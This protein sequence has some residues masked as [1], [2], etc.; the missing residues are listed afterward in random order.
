MLAQVSSLGLSRGPTPHLGSEL[1]RQSRAAAASAC[2]SKSRE[3]DPRIKSEDDS[4]G[5][6]RRKAERGGSEAWWPPAWSEDDGVGGCG[7]GGLHK[8]ALT[9]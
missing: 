1:K 2:M 8:R 7:K 5:R 4:G 9:P 3:V 6:A